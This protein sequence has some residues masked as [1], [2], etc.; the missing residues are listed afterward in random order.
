MLWLYVN[1]CNYWRRRSYL[2]TMKYVCKHYIIYITT[3]PHSYSG[4]SLGATQ[5]KRLT[6][7][8]H[9]KNKFILL[10]LQWIAYCSFCLYNYEF[11]LSLCKI[12]RSS[13]ILLLPL[14]IREDAS[15]FLLNCRLYIE[16]RTILLNFFH[17]HNFRK[18]IGTLLFGLSKRPW[19]HDG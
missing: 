2:W 7:C 13:V 14:F 9:S 3:S 12:V 16:Q 10:F 5:R 4:E 1:W 19:E 17:H 8:I 6:F 15:H 18:D 11:W